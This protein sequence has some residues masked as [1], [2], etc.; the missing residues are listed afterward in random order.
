MCASEYCQIVYFPCRR[1]PKV[2]QNAPPLRP[3]LLQGL[4]DL[5]WNGGKP[6]WSQTKPMS[7]EECVIRAPRRQ[8]CAILPRLHSTI[9]PRQCPHAT[10]A[11]PH[12]FM[13]ANCDAVAAASGGKTA[14]WVCVAA[15]PRARLSPANSHPPIT[16]F[17]RYRNGIKALPWHTSVRKLLED[18]SR[19]GMFMPLAGCMPTPGNYVCG[20]NA[21]QNLYHD[22]EQ[23][24]KGD[25]G[26]GI[27]CGECESDRCVR[28]RGLAAPISRDRPSPSAPAPQTSSITA[29]RPSAIFSLASTSSR[30][31]SPSLSR[32]TTWMT[33]GRHG[34]RP[35]W[36]P[37]LSRRW[38]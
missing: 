36:T 13:V 30:S 23:T 37:T 28:R 4:V 32:A 19:W 1:C 33:I 14:C 34:G 27:E 35:R 6:V 24:P 8:F 38:A 9:R 21:T 18:K 29:T 20:P 16:S 25:C 26:A 5:D 31:R 10:P 7:A 3:Y 12:R 11:H 15:L 17:C 2:S 22:F